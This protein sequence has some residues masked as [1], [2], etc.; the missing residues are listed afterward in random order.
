VFLTNSL[1]EIV[2]VVRVGRETIGTEKP[3]ETTA[4]LYGA[5]GELVERECADA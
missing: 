1:M 2:P 5:Y 4:Q 3:G